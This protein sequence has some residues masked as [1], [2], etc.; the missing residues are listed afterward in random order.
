MKI[1]VIEKNEVIR[2]LINHVL[3]KEGY[4]ITMA[5]NGKTAFQYLSDNTFDIVITNIHLQY[6]SGFELIT[7]IKSQPHLVETK[8]V[9]LSD[10]FTSENILR[11]YKMGIDDMIEK[12]F[13]PMEMICRLGKLSELIIK[14]RSLDRFIA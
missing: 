11:L 12:P 14:L 8:I 9:V 1:L 4:E 6:Y 5:V 3:S 10:N 7:H 13:T 2:N